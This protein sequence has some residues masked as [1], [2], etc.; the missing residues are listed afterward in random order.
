MRI[1]LKSTLVSEPKIISKS[2]FVGLAS[3]KFDFKKIEEF[4][5]LNLEN[6]ILYFKDNN[7]L[8]KKHFIISLFLYKN[9]DGDWVIYSDGQMIELKDFENKII[10]FKKNSFYQSRII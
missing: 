10:N 2:S 1:I 7:N 4:K 8:I 3:D 5:M 6:V 9:L